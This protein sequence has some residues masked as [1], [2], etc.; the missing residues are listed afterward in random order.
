MVADI[1][2]ICDGFR[3]IMYHIAQSLGTR[4]ILVAFLTFLI[5]TLGIFILTPFKNWLAGGIGFILGILSI[6]TVSWFISIMTAT[7]VGST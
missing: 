4:Y 6:P 1:T 5:T 3:E 2:L 7:C